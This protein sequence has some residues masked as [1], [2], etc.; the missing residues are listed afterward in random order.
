MDIEA[1]LKNRENPKTLSGIARTLYSEG[2]DY[3]GLVQFLRARFVL[4][5][6][7]G[8][9]GNYSEAAEAI[10]L[11]RHRVGEEMQCLHLRPRD[12]REVARAIRTAR[13]K[14]ARRANV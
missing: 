11:E 10:G 2:M 4:E 5:A 3:K 9:G 14:E 1:W 8:S 13:L 6:V 12:V 7:V